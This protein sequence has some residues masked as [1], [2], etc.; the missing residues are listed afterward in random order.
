[1]GNGLIQI[2]LTQESQWIF[3]SHLHSMKWV[4]FSLRTYLVYFTAKFKG[5]KCP[6]SPRL[7]HHPWQHTCV[8]PGCKGKQ[9]LTS[10]TSTCRRNNNTFKMSKTTFCTLEVKWFG[11]IFAESGVSVDPN[12]MKA[13]VGIGKPQNT[14]VKSLDQAAAY[15]AKFAFVSLL[16]ST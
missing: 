13:K 8:R 2:P 5:L 16:L 3:Q 15:N 11:R 12:K 4:L 9:Q 7:Y 1:M 14:E 6:R 10:Y